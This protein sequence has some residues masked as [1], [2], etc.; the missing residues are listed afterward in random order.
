MTCALQSSV[1]EVSPN[2]R[3]DGTPLLDAALDYAAR[4]WAVLPLH[5]PT[6]DGRCSCSNP[7]CASPAKHPRTTHGLKD[8]TTDPDTIRRWWSRWPT[9]NIGIVCGPESFVVLD[10]DRHSP[11]ADGP[12][13]AEAR[14]EWEAEGPLAETGGGGLHCFYRHPGGHV[15]SRCGAGAIAPG[16]EL[17]GDGSYIVAPPSVH[18]SGRAY[19]WRHDPDLEPMTDLP[20]WALNG[21]A[22]DGARGQT[23]TDAGAP[24]PRVSATR[25]SRVWPAPCANGA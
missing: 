21:A 6:E 9:A 23:P 15:K 10:L 16:V 17:R 5:S 12:A 11:E 18:I 25:P 24:S 13:I 1:S 8:A 4:G 2:R 3:Q 20:A 14:F 22:G 19:T 7:K